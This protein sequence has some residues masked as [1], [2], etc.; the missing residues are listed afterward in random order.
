MNIFPFHFFVAFWGVLGAVGAYL[1]YFRKDAGFKRKYF[2]KYAIFTGVVFVT[3]PVFT[4]FPWQML[5]ISVPF[6]ALIIYLN[7]RTTRFC[8]QCGRTN[9]SQFPFAM[10][11]FC[12]KC[13]AKLHD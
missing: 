3:V 12:S 7:V 4:G 13:G 5:A 11:K 8:D 9:F 1:F 2:R 6:V 10:P